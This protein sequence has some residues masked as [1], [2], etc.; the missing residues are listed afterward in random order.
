MALAR[1]GASQDL[2]Q[3]IVNASMAVEADP[4]EVRHWHLLALLLGKRENWKAAKGALEEGA[5]L[6]EEDG[7]VAEV[8][9]EEGAGSSQQKVEHETADAVTL[10]GST[11]PTSPSHAPDATTKA[12]RNVLDPDATKIPP[13]ASLLAPVFDY[14]PPSPAEAFEHSLQLRMTQV[15]LTEYMEGPESAGIKWFQVFKW[16]AARKGYAYDQRM[17]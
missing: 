16:I 12:S 1:P 4:K 6:G 15:A 7:S 17:S 10:D 14:P 9:P 11:K 13:A 2:D 8:S 5:V 3:A